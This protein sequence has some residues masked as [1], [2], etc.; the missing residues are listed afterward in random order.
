ML[1]NRI[2]GCRQTKKQN[3]VIGNS[4]LGRRVWFPANAHDGALIEGAGVVH[5]GFRDFDD[6]GSIV[7]VLGLSKVSNEAGEVIFEKIVL[8]KIRALVDSAVAAGAKRIKFRLENSVE[9]RYCGP[10]SKNHGK[11]VISQGDN[12]CGYVDLNGSWDSFR[13]PE[14]V[15]QSVLEFDADPAKAAKLSAAHTS[16][17]CFCGRF[18]END[19]SI[20]AGYGPVCAEKFGLPWQNHAEN[21]IELSCKEKAS[22][23]EAVDPAADRE[24]EAREAY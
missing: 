10:R 19:G 13:A 17:C 9:I 14:D 2:D 16:S 12:F 8:E 23:P 4:P 3:G 7:F 20:E 5:I 21:S 6:Q 11:L 18:L 15:L 1:E 22:L 24:R